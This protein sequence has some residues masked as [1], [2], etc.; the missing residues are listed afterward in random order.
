MNCPSCREACPYI[1]KES[2]VI[3]ELLQDMPCTTTCGITMV[4]RHRDAHVKECVECLR[5]LLAVHEEHSD[6]YY[7]LYAQYL[8]AENEYYEVTRTVEDDEDEDA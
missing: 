3:R 5:A 6:T 2:L 1:A 8:G 7:K 4:T